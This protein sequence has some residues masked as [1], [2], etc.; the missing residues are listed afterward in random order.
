MWEAFN[1]FL[2][3]TGSPSSFMAWPSSG[4]VLLVPLTTSEP[5][6]SATPTSPGETSPSPSP[7]PTV[8]VT[9]TAAAEP[10]PESMKLDGEQ[11]GVMQVSFVLMILFLAAILF[12]QMRKP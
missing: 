5:S 7:A 4:Q 10:L 3:T 1:S 2:I 6:A 9:Q 8:T 12:A 11:F